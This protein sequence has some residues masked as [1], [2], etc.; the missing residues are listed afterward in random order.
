MK[1]SD[2]ALAI[3]AVIA[4]LMLWQWQRTHPEFDLSDLITGENG[5]VSATKFAQTAALVVATWG[6][7][8]L[9]QQG[10]MTEW[11]FIGYLTAFLGTRVAKDALAVKAPTP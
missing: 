2:Y 5:K 7:V 8:T 1:L 9:V 10:K 3:G 6:F 4:L 11:Y